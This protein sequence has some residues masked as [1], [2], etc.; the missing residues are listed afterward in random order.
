MTKEKT[1]DKDLSRP[2]PPGVSRIDEIDRRAEAL[3]ENLKKRKAQSR[4]NASG[5]NETDNAS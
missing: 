5:K 1:S 2:L 4:S 3:R